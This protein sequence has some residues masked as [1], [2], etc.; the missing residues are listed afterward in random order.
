M[1]IFLQH[2]NLP[3]ENPYSRLLG[4]PEN[5]QDPD[6]YQL[7]GLPE[8]H[9]SKDEV[10]KAY[11]ERIQKL[12]RVG[13]N[14]KYKE[15]VLYLRGELRS[16]QAT[17]SNSLRKSEYDLLL[18]EGRAQQLEK[19]LE[20]LTI[21]GYLV[22]LEI[23]YLKKR[24]RELKI[25]P[26][27]LQKMLGPVAVRSGRDERR[28]EP[29]PVFFRW[30]LFRKMALALAVCVLAASALLFVDRFPFRSRE[31]VGT[32]D[33]GQG[34]RSGSAQSET[35]AEKSPLPAGPVI[36][37]AGVQSKMVYVRGGYF[38]L[39][40]AQGNIDENPVRKI[41]LEDYYIARHEVT[42]REYREFVES[43]GHCVPYS[44]LPEAKEFNWDP[45]DLSY[46]EKSGECPVVLVSWHDATAYCRWLSGRY[47]CEASLPTEAQWEKAA[48][49]AESSVYPWGNNMPENRGELGNFYGRHDGFDRLAPVGSFPWG[50]SPTGC[51]D[52]A[53]NAAEW[54]LD[55]YDKFA[56]QSMPERDPCTE[57]ADWPW[58]VVRG[59]SWLDAIDCSRSSYRWPAD[60]DDR[61]I[62]WGF[63]YVVIPD[64]PE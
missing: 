3:M 58:K 51:W 57:R 1:W 55:S 5:L 41:Y 43:T 46:P 32:Q 34:V 50:I 54:C 17:L 22:N 24:A 15:M 25:S 10:E 7:L 53:G 48:R 13:N 2:E 59:G 12:Q 39:G 40:N 35:P 14:P 64:R 8:G 61:S 52:M 28:P 47:G 19:E 56:Y 21:K 33:S 27:R 49:G 38:W 37:D 23:S 60:A 44:A 26:A 45:L 36:P 62:R 9:L 63:R 6:Y 30:S 29:G 18:L 16:A 42:N 31:T 20:L 4:F 11:R